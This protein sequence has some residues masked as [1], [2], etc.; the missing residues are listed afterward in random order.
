MEGV[1]VARSGARR[2]LSPVI[3]IVSIILSFVTTAQATGPPKTSIYIDQIPLYNELPQCAQDP[4]SAIIRAQSSGCGDDQQLTSFSCFCVQGSAKFSSI[5]STAV[6]AGCAATTSVRATRSTTKA[7][8]SLPPN[9]GPTE[10]VSSALEAF[11]S[12]CERTTELP[13]Y[14]DN[15]TQTTPPTVIITT[16]PQTITLPPGATTTSSS[17]STSSHSK[18]TNVAAIVVPVVLVPLLAGLG[19]FFFLRHRRNTRRPHVNELYAG[20]S[21]LNEKRRRRGDVKEVGGGSQTELPGDYRPRQE[22]AGSNEV[23]KYAHELQNNE[24]ERAELDGG[25]VKDGKVGVEKK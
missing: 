13:W 18:K 11:N 8:V 12:Y 21:S 15:S 1:S 14:A 4:V 9:P 25:E 7:S 23:V 2:D 20:Q 5:I 24:T 3:I 19:L 10:G 16:P 17:A 22:V 6:S